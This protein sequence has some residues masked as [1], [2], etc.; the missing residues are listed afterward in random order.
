MIKGSSASPIPATGERMH[1]HLRRLERVWIGWPI[2]F[3]TTCTLGRRAILAAKEVSEILTDEWRNGRSRHGWAV[4]RYVIMPDPV[5]LFWPSRI[6]CQTS[7]S[8]H[9]KYG[10]NGAASEWRV[11]SSYL[12]QSGRKNSSTMFCARARAT[13]R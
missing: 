8:L 6:R 10:R 9:A 11:I 13:V 2:Y 1:K 5:H 3:I 4:G 7:S 12:E